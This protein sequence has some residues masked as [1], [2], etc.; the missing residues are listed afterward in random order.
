MGVTELIGKLKL[1][2]Q[3]PDPL[4][5]PSWPSILSRRGEGSVYALAGIV[6]LSGVLIGQF[7]G[8]LKWVFV[9][10]AV[11]AF[12]LGVGIYRARAERQRRLDKMERD[13]GEEVEA[14]WL[15]VL[16]HRIGPL[17]LQVL[18]VIAT[19]DPIDRKDRASSARTAILTL[20]AADV[21]GDKEAVARLNLFKIWGEGEEL[22]MRPEPFCSAGRGTKE[23][24]RV[25]EAADD[26]TRV[27]LEGDSRFVESVRDVLGDE[28]AAKLPYE[29]FATTPVG[30]PGPQSR[31]WGVLTADALK[32]GELRNDVT[33]HSW[34]FS[35]R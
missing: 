4:E 18:K 2:D 11:V 13:V 10:V 8:W 33:S 24:S 22:E 34:E 1:P 21:I 29:T 28:E 19:A 12:L 15:W 14:K 6:S 26:T 16:E 5:Q 7:D 31:I 35:L 25:F 32:S 30:A 17:L 27:T 23:S 3:E 20:A 9:G